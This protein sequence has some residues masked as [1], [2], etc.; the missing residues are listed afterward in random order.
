M[1]MAELINVK[2]LSDLQKF[3]DDLPVKMEKNIMRGALRA[4]C[5]IVKDEAVSLVPMGPPSSENTKI[6][7]GYIGAL[8]DS[9]RVGTRSKGGTV[10]A[11]V[12]AGGKTKRGADV[13]YAHMFEYTGGR[14]HQ[15]KAK[16]GHYLLVAGGHPIAEVSHPGFKATPFMRPALDRE[17]QAAVIAAGNYIKDR[18]A[19][20]E[21]LDTSAITIEGDE[22]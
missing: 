7:G 18:L 9:I 20:K 3:L 17:A 5:N 1:I 19:T 12:K 22:P 2:G 8:R 14:K 6:Y 13:Y 21:G 4:G 10:T 16:P 11:Y 15:I